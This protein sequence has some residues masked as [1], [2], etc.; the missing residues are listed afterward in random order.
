MHSHGCILPPFRLSSTLMKSSP[1]KVS[2]ILLAG[3]QGSR[4]QSQTPKQFL[5]LQ[6]K[7]VALHSFEQFSSCPH[8][9]EII[10]VC[11]PQFHSLFPRFTLPEVR[12]ALP[13]NRRQ[14]SV[15]NGFLTIS[16]QPDLICV[17]DSARPFLSKDSLEQLL[18]EARRYGAA[19]LAVPAKNT[20]K[21]TDPNQFIQRT[22]DR[23]KLWEMHTPQVATP[24]LLKK[25]FDIALEYNL[26]VTDDAS[27]VELTGHPVKLVKDSYQN[28]KI[29]TPE[30]WQVALHTRFP[31]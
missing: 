6:G 27:L 11:E 16:S 13:G 17:H 3:G 31:L 20:I 8:V 25:G 24:A 30:D 26:D 10:V 12:F 19:A 21:E 2:V 29:T 7:P 23:S 18:E 4:M 1:Y 9:I 15:Y 14:D 22:L 5:N 28:F